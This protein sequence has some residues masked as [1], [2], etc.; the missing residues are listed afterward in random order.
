M[1]HNPLKLSIF[2]ILFIFVAALGAGCATPET[3]ENVFTSSVTDVVPTDKI[4]STVTSQ[5]S[6]M[7]PATVPPTSIPTA[8][9][10]LN[11]LPLYWP[12]SVVEITEITAEIG[13]ADWVLTESMQDEESTCTFFE[14]WSWS[15]S[16]NQASNCIFDRATAPEN[17]IEKLIAYMFETRWEAHQKF[18]IGSSIKL[19]GEHALFAGYAPSGQTIFDV[20]VVD[21]GT[22]A[23]WASITLGTK[24]DFDGM[25][26]TPDALY[27][28]NAAE[29]N[30][31]LEAILKVNF[32]GVD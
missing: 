13:I 5:P 25:A 32:E 20:L 26:I 24:P 17:S 4:E 8:D 21:G 23:Y 27:E 1:N 16:Q 3:V 12:V 2:I 18:Q 22:H 11:K 15:T 30:Q 14:G 9:A 28:N 10:S 19:P 31:I 6:T 7:Q 29:I